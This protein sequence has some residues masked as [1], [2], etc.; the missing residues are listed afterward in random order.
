[1][2]NKLLKACCWNWTNLLRT[3]ELRMNKSPAGRVHSSDSNTLASFSTLL[4]PSISPGCFSV[5]SSWVIRTYSC[6]LS[7]INNWKLS[8]DNFRRPSR[9]RRHQYKVI[10][11]QTFR[12]RPQGLSPRIAFDDFNFFRSAAVIE[13]LCLKRF[14]SSRVYFALSDSVG[15]Y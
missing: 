15:D 3:V 5:A 11:S 6:P 4:V 9:P 1:M 7:S 8:F 10:R 2:E 14:L 13:G 12:G